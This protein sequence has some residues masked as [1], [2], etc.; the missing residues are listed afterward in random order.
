MNGFMSVKET[1]VCWGVSVRTVTKYCNEGRVKG[2]EMF[3]GS[4]IIPVDSEKPRDTR[5]RD[6]FSSSNNVKPI[7]KW[8]GGKGQ[9]LEQIKAAYPP[10]LGDVI[11][12]YAEPFIGGAAVLFDILSRYCM[13]QVYISDV[14]RELVHL[15]QTVRDNHTEL[16]EILSNLQNDHISRGD[17]ERKEFYNENR[18]RYNEIKLKEDVDWVECSALFV[19][20][21]KT[22]FNG[23]YRVNS[24]GEFN[25]PSGVYKNP[26]ICDAPN[27]EKAHELLQNVRIECADFSASEQFIDGNTFVYFDPPYRPLTSTS[28]FTSYTEGQFDDDCQRRLAE[29]VHMLSD[30]G[31]KIMVSNS[32]PQNTNPNDT[33]FEKLYAGMNIMKVPASRMI[34]SKG[35]GRGKINELLITNYPVPETG[36]LR[37]NCFD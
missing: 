9:L 34:N 21:N 6:D 25:V 32:D 18:M 1:S 22:C 31:A 3:S 37:I 12:K 7:V 15:Y 10:G 5:I 11:T 23:L 30:K 26:C 13:E 29:Y 27:I 28:S 2:A 16:I 20:L 14:N 19:Y 35:S 4:W 36:Q 17:S 8:A 33:F 24:K